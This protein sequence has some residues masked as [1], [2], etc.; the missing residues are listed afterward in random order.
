[1]L[2]DNNLIYCRPILNLLVILY[3][4]CWVSL[5][6]ITET[7]FLEG[8]TSATQESWVFFF[9]GFIQ[10]I[11]ALKKNVHSKGK[12]L[13][14]QRKKTDFI[15]YDIDEAMRVNVLWH[16]LT[17]CT[18][19]TL[20]QHRKTK[21]KKTQKRQERKKSVVSSK[22]LYDEVFGCIFM[23]LQKNKWTGTT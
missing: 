11:R 20:T 2:L 4:S 18:Q 13:Q 16:K 6:R 15:G 22:K 17:T 12:E 10:S 19:R 14:N 1:M 3:I 23:S 7:E 5:D 21:K 9:L 8:L